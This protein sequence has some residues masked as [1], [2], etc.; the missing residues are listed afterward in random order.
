MVKRVQYRRRSMTYTSRAARVL[1]KLVTCDVSFHRSVTGVRLLVG[2]M[3]INTRRLRGLRRLRGGVGR[4]TA[5]LRRRLLTRVPSVST[6]CAVSRRTC[7]R[8][9]TRLGQLRT[10]GRETRGLRRRLR[11]VVTRQRRGGSTVRADVLGSLN[12]KARSSTRSSFD[13]T[14]FLSEGNA[15]HRIRRDVLSSLSNMCS[16]RVSRR[17]PS[18]SFTSE[19]GTTCRGL[20]RLRERTSLPARVLRRISR[21]VQGLRAVARVRCLLAFRSIAVSKLAEGMT[22]CEG[23]LTRG[24]TRFCR[25]LTECGTLYSVTGRSSRRCVCS[26]SSTIT[27]SSRI[28]ELRGT[29]IGRRRRTCVYRYIGRIVSSV[30]CSLVNRQS[31]AGEG[32]GEFHGRLFSFGSNAT[33]GIACSPG[34]RVSVRLNNVTHRSHLP[35]TRRISMLARSVRAFYNRFTRFR[36]HLE[37]GN[38]VINGHVTLSP[39]ATSCTTVVGIA[40]CRIRTDARIP[41]VTTSSGG[42]HASRGGIVQEGR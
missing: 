10:V 30:N 34:K 36:E 1:Q 38:I 32:K 27:L 7:T 18:A 4:R 6:G 3:G 21:T 40:S 8:G 37:S 22:R 9:R 29:L 2:E 17:R 33:I 12:L 35:A 28:R 42:G 24:R 11:R 16:F 13:K 14:S 31:I 5:R 20:R 15:I 41:R 23:R 25:L 39:P 19:G 26:R